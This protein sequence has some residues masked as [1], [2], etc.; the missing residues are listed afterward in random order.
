MKYV[1]YN[2]IMPTRYSAA[3]AKNWSRELKAEMT[4]ICVR[5]PTSGETAIL[6]VDTEVE[7]APIQDYHILYG[8]S[9][10]FHVNL[11]EGFAVPLKIGS[12]SSLQ[13]CLSCSLE[14]LHELPRGGSFCLPAFLER[15]VFFEA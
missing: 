4:G 9:M 5:V 10:S 11:G 8:S 6:Q 13:M 2:H 1:N 15:V 7:R 12:L 3:G 14:N